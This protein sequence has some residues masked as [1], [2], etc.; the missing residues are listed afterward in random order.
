MKSSHFIFDHVSHDTSYIRFLDWIKNKKP[1]INPTKKHDN[2][3]VQ[4]DATATLNYK[5]F[6]E[7]SERTF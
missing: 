6:E 1:I 4:Y 5:E 2:K 7:K 3:R